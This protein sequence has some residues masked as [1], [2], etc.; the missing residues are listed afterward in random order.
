MR[1]MVIQKP[2]VEEKE[3]EEQRLG[4]TIATQGNVEEGQKAKLKNELILQLEQSGHFDKSIGLLIEMP[5][6]S[7]TDISD[8]SLIFRN[9]LQDTLGIYRQDRRIA[10]PPIER[11]TYPGSPDLYITINIAEIIVNIAEIVGAGYLSWKLLDTILKNYPNIR[12]MFID[13]RKSKTF[14]SMRRRLMRWWR[15]PSKRN[16]IKSKKKIIIYIIILESK[17]QK[18]IEKKEVFRS[19]RQ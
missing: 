11:I 2:E 5:G 10:D 15:T 3:R 1:Q 17:S 8:F 7:L 18:I 6:I 4:K 19:S 14:K 16:R 9:S 13:I 12:A